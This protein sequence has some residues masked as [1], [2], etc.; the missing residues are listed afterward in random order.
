MRILAIAVT[1]CTLLSV[2]CNSDKSDYD[3]GI[4]AYERGHYRTALYDFEKRANQGDRV[5]QFCLGYMSKNGKGMK[6]NYQTALDWYTKAVKQN[7]PPA[8]NNLA[9]MYDDGWFDSKGEKVN[10]DI[11][12][13]EELWKQAAEKGNPT[14]Q[15]NLGFMYLSRAYLAEQLNYEKA[16][17]LLYLEEAEKLLKE[18]TVQ[19][20][21]HAAHFL[22]MVYRIKAKEA[23]D[24]GDFESANKLYKMQENSYKDADNIA[25]AEEKAAG[26][27][28]KDIKGYAPAQND[29]GSM[30]Y[31]GEGVAQSL[32]ENERWK[33]ALKWYAQAAEQGRAGS[34]SSL[35]FMYYL[36]QGVDKDDK[37]AMKLWKKAAE[38]G[39][40]SAQNSL[41]NMY[42]KEARDAKRNADERTAKLNHEMA[43]RW[44]LRAAQQGN[45]F[46]QVNL[47][48]NFEIGRNGVPQ[49]NAEAYCWYSLA[50][51]DP[52]S[53]NS[54]SDDIYETLGETT[55]KVQ[56]FATKVNE[57]HESVGNHLNEEPKKKIQERVDN[58]KPKYDPP[59]YGT[60]F[61]IHENYILTNEHVVTGKD[62]E[63]NNHEFDEFRIPY[64]RVEL[65]AW[66][67]NVD[68]AL[69][70]DERGNTDTAT[71]RSDLVYKDE[72]ITSFGY[73]YSDWLSYEGNSTPGTVSGPFGMLNM[74]HPENYFQHTA[75]VQPGNSGGPVF[76]LRGDVVGVTK[77][78]AD[79]TVRLAQ[80]IEISPPQNVNFAI[81][82]DVIK[83]FL[84][85]N[86]FKEDSGDSIDKEKIYK[87]RNTSTNS[88]SNQGD[89]SGKAKK[90]TV[91][92]LS[93][94]NKDEK[95][96]ETDYGTKEIE[97]HQ[98]L[99][100]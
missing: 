63:G 22:G 81:R 74:S 90:F 45:A 36:G 48:Q 46:A 82:F 6:V 31:K 23:T 89:I 83:E 99:K 69:L 52:D 64:R 11:D 62:Y 56:N 93:F 66:D 12:K 38:Q 30:Y 70:Y 68:L 79:L 13:A 80:I 47:G 42:A 53:L 5:A 27:E 88:A 39:D 29:L 17:Q 61:Y 67:P 86:G 41:A 1:F 85:K 10:P 75:P 77:Y 94:K 97:I 37:K 28:D 59:G 20:L 34:Q 3:V 16:K 87:V 55:S 73:P 76:D 14:A 91:P 95:T 32:T 7:Y 49:N 72:K 58:W 40:V 43:S 84:E 100:P 96:F 51:R 44:Y 25:R 21:P 24:N 26:K 9:K 35:A 78:R 60:G 8:M 19:Q 15:T 18:A 92:V 98:G 71:F 57:W 54:G 33:E 65:I 4:T 2:G 50:L